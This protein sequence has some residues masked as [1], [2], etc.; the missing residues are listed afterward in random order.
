MPWAFYIGESSGKLL[1]TGPSASVETFAQSCTSI[2]GCLAIGFSAPSTDDPSVNGGFGVYNLYQGTVSELQVRIESV[3]SAD[4]QA[5]Q[6]FYDIGCFDCPAP[7]SQSSAP[8][9]VPMTT[10]IAIIL[11]NTVVSITPTL[12]CPESNDKCSKTPGTVQDVYTQFYD[13][14]FLITG[15]DYSRNTEP[16]SLPPISTNLDPSLS[17]CEAANAC[18]QLCTQDNGVYFSFDLHFE[19]LG[20]K[21]VCV[22]YFDPNV[23]G[24]AD[25]HYPDPQAVCVYEFSHSFE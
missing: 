12:L 20:N 13:G 23:N 3:P 1:E 18:V 22:Q 15:P 7:M 17:K 11:T 8:V 5:L 14:Q 21:W 4:G 19:L 2:I 10:S 9:I 25:F 24:A 6:E 16:S